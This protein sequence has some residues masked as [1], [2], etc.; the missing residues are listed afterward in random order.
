M[1]A[2]KASFDKKGTPNEI[3]ARKYLRWAGNEAEAIPYIAIIPAGRADEP[4]TFDAFVTKKQILE[5]L[6][7]AGA[8][9]I[10]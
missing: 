10:D 1:I 4:I 5:A 6:E 3:F 8:S 9:Q 2:A 7:E